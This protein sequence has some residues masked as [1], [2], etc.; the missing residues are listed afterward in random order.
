MNGPDFE[1]AELINFK[2]TIAGVHQ[3]VHA[4]NGEIGVM[5]AASQTTPTHGVLITD[6]VETAMNYK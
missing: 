4:S 6:V 5:F 2:L 1:I 3:S